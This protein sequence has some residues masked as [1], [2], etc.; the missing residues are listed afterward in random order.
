MNNP[1]DRRALEEVATR[2]RAEG[3]PHCVATV[4]RTLSS[5]AAKPG[6]KAIVLEDG[7][8][9]EGWLGG[10][11]VTA[12]VRKASIKAIETGAAT[13]VCLR[14]EELL[15]DMEA[16][17]E[18]VQLARNGCPSKGSMDIFVEPVTPQPELFIYGSG[19]VAAALLH[20]AAAFG[21]SLQLCGQ[22]EGAAT[23]RQFDTPA[24]VQAA[25]MI[26]VARYVV[27]ATQG[28]GDT[29]SLVS[30]LQL[31]AS[32]IAFV[33]SRRKFASYEPKLRDAGIAADRIASVRSPAGVNIHAVTPEE[34]ALSIMAEIVQTRRV[35]MAGGHGMAE[36]TGG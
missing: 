1:A 28:K 32:Y 29:A 23:D 7:E 14:P 34:I 6:M 27:V 31:D 2:L 21:Y 25:N 13:L 17:G 22:I 24:D 5:T 19:P 35:A 20:I 11:C 4:V 36:Q 18:A 30:A 10:G 12:A 26:P 33:G 8:F 16:E 9:A 3:T 15:A